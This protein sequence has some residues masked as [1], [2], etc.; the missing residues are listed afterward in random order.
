MIEITVWRLITV[1]GYSSNQAVNI[2]TFK[3]A[4]ACQQ[5]QKNLPNARFVESRCIQA[6]ILVVK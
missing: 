6:T 1:G 5:L 3:T 2:G 4:S